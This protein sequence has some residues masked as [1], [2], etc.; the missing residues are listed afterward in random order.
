MSAGIYSLCG[1]RWWAVRLTPALLG[2][3]YLGS[4]AVAA[5][6]Y[7]TGPARIWL[8][9]F[10][11]SPMLLIYSTVPEVNAGNLGA[12]VL[13]Y[14][15]V[16][17]YLESGAQR[18]MIW[19]GILYL[20]GFWVN[21]LALAIVPPIVLQIALHQR[22]PWRQR[23]Q[24]LLV[25]VGFVLLGAGGAVAHLAFLPGALDWL[26]GRAVYRFSASTGGVADAHV[27][28]VDFAV[29]QTVRLATHYTPICVALAGV[30]VL[31]ALRRWKPRREGGSRGGLHSVRPGTVLFQ[32]LLWGLPFG[33]LAINYAYIHAVSLYYFLIFMAYGS[34]LAL[35]WVTGGVGHLRGRRILGSA[36]VAVFLVLSIARSLFAM[37]GGSLPALV[38]GRLPA[39]V[40]R[41]VGAGDRASGDSVIPRDQW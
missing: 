27:S 32:F 18:W 33:A 6:N 15:C 1:Q 31:M 5:L 30:G 13:S 19:A 40:T 41:G 3:V 10:A 8:L 37:S 9:Y 36:V 22:L 34:A 14:L 21:Y 11:L 26:M 16:T 38:G 20:L 12:L 23:R 24:A 29:R 2:L 35:S 39:W 25:W 7:L 17:K 28:L 4:C